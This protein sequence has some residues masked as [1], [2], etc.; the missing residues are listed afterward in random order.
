MVLQD[1]IDQRI[2]RRL[3]SAPQRATSDFSVLFNATTVTLA[4]RADRD[5]AAIP[6]VSE[7]DCTLAAR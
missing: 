7:G 4:A 1:W 3:A 6:V 5:S 2:L